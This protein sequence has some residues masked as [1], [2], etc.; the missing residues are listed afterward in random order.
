[1]KRDIPGYE[2]KYAVTRNGRVWSHSRPVRT[3]GNS[4]R[5][6]RGRW[7]KTLWPRSG[8]PSV[9]LGIGNM[10]AIHRLVAMAWLP[11]VPGKDFVNHKD[12]NRRNNRVENLEWCTQTENNQ[13]AWRTGLS[14]PMPRCLNASES[15]EICALIAAGATQQEVARKYGV[16]R[17]TVQRAIARSRISD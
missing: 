13:H 10:Q 16:G 14:K 9:Q 2:G 6:I 1:M 3:L 8:Y 4:F 11:R 17:T 15:R 7:L 12:G 5:I